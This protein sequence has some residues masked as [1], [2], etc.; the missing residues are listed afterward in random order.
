M[1][2]C[3]GST[4]LIQRD[5]WKKGYSQEQFLERPSEKA[6]FCKKS[7]WINL[8]S[9]LNQTKERKT[10]LFNTKLRSVVSKSGDWS[11][12]K[13]LQF[14]PYYISMDHKYSWWKF[15]KVVLFS[16]TK[17]PKVRVTTKM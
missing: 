15:G 16:F 2:T 14:T 10:N 11:E 6:L 12:L 5:L 13:R 1:L 3:V 8:C 7:A 17:L 4:E 9:I